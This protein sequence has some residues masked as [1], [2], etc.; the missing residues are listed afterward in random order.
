[1]SA[2]PIGTTITTAHDPRT[3]DAE[4]TITVEMTAVTAIA[5]TET[6]IMIV[7]T[8]IEMTGMIE[9]TPV[10]I[11]ATE[12]ATHAT[13]GGTTTTA[14]EMAIPTINGITMHLGPTHHQTGRGINCNSSHPQTEQK[15]VTRLT[16]RVLNVTNSATMLRNARQP[17]VAKLLR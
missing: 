15:P 6:T 8:M 16:L 13:I 1:M 10:T 12:T 5:T 11:G 14:D 9:G 3:D 7:M 17:T 4:T 2:I